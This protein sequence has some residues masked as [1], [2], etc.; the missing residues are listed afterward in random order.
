M[1]IVVLVF[2]V[3]SMAF[4][5]LAAI[6]LFIV[7]GCKQA[8]ILQDAVSCT[9]Q[10]LNLREFLSSFFVQDAME[11]VAAVCDSASL[12]TCDLIQNRMMLSTILTTVFS[13]LGSFMFLNL[14]IDSVM[15]HEQARWR[16]VANTM[17]RDGKPGVEA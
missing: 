10:L 12:L 8:D 15:K 11:P 7:V 9:A 2:F 17:V 4:C 3:V 13:L 6:K 5:I 16:R 1:Q 14:I